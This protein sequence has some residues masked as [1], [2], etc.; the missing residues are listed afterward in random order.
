MLLA[1]PPACL[2]S[3]PASQTDIVLFYAQISCEHLVVFPSKEHFF[4]F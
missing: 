3:Q 1:F 2:C 4:L